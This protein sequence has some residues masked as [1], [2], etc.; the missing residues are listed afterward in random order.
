MSMMPFGDPFGFERSLWPS[1]YH[2][3]STV[4]PW[5]MGGGYLDQFFNDSMRQM[6][7]MERGLGEV[8]LTDSGDFRWRCNVSGYKPDELKVDLDGNQLVVSGEHKESREGESIHR[9]FTRRV[10]LPENV[11]KDTIK[12]HIDE[13]G[14]LEIEARRPAVEGQKQSIPIGFKQP[15][16]EQQ[17]A[18][19]Q[20]AA[21]K[22]QAGR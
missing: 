15:T 16:V 4:S 1:H 3:R 20:S 14:R 10:V 22:Q 5:T 13:R 18:V 9:N 7:D 21:G 17:K 12:C 19:D 6:M 8:N 2:R 11:Q